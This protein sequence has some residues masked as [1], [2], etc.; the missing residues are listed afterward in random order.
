MHPGVLEIPVTQGAASSAVCPFQTQFRAPAQRK[1][2]FEADCDLSIF[3]R[4][5]L[6]SAPLC[7]FRSPQERHQLAPQQ[8]LFP[9]KAAADVLGFPNVMVLTPYGR[10]L[11]L[12]QTMMSRL[13]A[14]TVHDHSL[15]HR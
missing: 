13:I 5:A 10:T 8:Y 14:F 9:E 7:V 11:I 6:K 4:I 15:G 3:F 2:N 12:A 1:C